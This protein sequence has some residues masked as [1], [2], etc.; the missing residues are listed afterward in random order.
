[1]DRA[2]AKV[3]VFAHTDQACRLRPTINT[4]KARTLSI[5]PDGARPQPFGN[6]E[7]PT[8]PELVPMP[9]VTALY[10]GILG[11]MAVAIAGAAGRLR[12]EVPI[13]DGGR[14]DVLVAMRRHANFVEV[15]PLVLILMALLE[16][17]KVSANAIHG[18][19]IAI[20]ISRGCHAFGMRGD[21]TATP[22]RAI[23]AVGSMLTSI[24]ASIWAITVF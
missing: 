24:V 5:E 22:L 12:G 9:T 13:G 8:M 18:I 17:N 23:G 6:Q 1:M 10:A 4:P 3:D 15:V 19:G 20:V 2:P 7:V 21:G 14:T 11:L 16:M